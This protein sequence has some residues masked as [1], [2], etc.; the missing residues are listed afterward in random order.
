MSFFGSEMG[1]ARAREAR[2]VVVSAP[3][4]WE[5]LVDTDNALV[6]ISNF[7]DAEIASALRKGTAL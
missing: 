7:D 1:E 6:L 4:A 3:G 5:R 2:A